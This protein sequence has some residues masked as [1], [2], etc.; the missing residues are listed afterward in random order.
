MVTAEQLEGFFEG[1]P[2][3]PSPQTLSRVLSRSTHVVLAVED[4]EVIGFVNALSDGELAAYVPLLEVRASH[5]HQGV[6]T[7]LVRRLTALLGDVYITDLTCDDDV[8][9]FYERLGFLRLNGMVRRNTEA[10]VLGTSSRQVHPLPGA[11]RTSA[12]LRQTHP[13]GLP[14]GSCSAEA[15]TPSS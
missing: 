7:E 13:R 8:V 15:Q 11:R 1:W 4:D 14:P 5:R 6:G 12:D 3:P 9:P 2:S 10:S